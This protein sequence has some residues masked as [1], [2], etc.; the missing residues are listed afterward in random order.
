MVDYK[1]M[2][3]CKK[4]IQKGKFDELTNYIPQ[5]NLI[6]DFIQQIF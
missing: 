4:Y 6:Q 1:L 3:L 5:N 2:E